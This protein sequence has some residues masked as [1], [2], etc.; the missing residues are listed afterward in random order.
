MAKQAADPIY[1][2]LNADDPDLGTTEIESMC[3]HCFKN[4]RTI[5][6]TKHS[7]QLN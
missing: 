2:S 7:M 5:Q 3:M 1:L 4:V 6:N